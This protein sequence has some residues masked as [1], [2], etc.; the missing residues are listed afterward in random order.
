L[1]RKG[2]LYLRAFPDTPIT[3]KPAGIRM[4]KGKG[5]V[6]Y[7]VAVLKPGQIIFEILGVSEKIAV[8]AIKSASKKISLIT[9]PVIRSSVL[10]PD[11]K[12][13]KG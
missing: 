4:G 11:A 13:K 8:R 9:G 1:D 3:S 7:W 10:D 12:K 2:K 5:A 6:D